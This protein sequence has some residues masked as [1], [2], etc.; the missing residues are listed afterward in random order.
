MEV[1]PGTCI[2]VL[3]DVISDELCETLKIVIDNTKGW[4]SDYDEG[5]HVKCKFL[6]IDLCENKK[7]A[8]VIDT[9]IHAVVSNII[10]QMYILNERLTPIN[11]DSGYQLRKIHGATRIHVDSI[12]CTLHDKIIPKSD[13]R[14][15]SLIIA[16]NSDY[17]GGEFYFPRQD[18]K[19]KLKGGQ[20]ILFPPYWTHPHY[21]GELNGTFRYAI[22]TWLLE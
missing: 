1:K 5:S 11:G 14:K 2:Y 18:I 12:F 22:N 15:L 7:L 13:L 4:I 9:E 3:D 20:A 19:L 21:T 17:E 8:K 6:S 16:L 10:K